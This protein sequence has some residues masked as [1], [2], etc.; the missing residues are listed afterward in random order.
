MKNTKTKLKFK[1]KNMFKRLQLFCICQWQYEKFVKYLL[2]KKSILNKFISCL[3]IY[4]ILINK[5][6]I[7]I[8]SFY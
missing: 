4:F 5:Q 8:V 6:E 3:L 7:L 2:L 1:M